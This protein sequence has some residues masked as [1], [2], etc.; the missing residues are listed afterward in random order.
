MLEGV[1]V[2]EF[3]ETHP[4]AR[5]VVENTEAQFKCWRPELTHEEMYRLLTVEDI[6]F[7]TFESWFGEPG[8]YAWYYPGGVP[9][10]MKVADAIN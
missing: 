1:K 6:K 2:K 10:Y 3:F 8:V 7:I 4:A 9:H 5:E